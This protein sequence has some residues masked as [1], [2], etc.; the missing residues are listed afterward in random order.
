M[1]SDRILLDPTSEVTP[2]VRQ[3]VSRPAFR[4]GLN[5]GLLDISKA[6]GNIFLD[7]LAEIMKNKGLQVQRY[8]KPTFARV[9]PTNL[10]QRLVESCDA[11]IEA[12]AD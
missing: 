4:T 9:A 3:R 2:A 8:T 6:R 7:R 12:L 5:V 1:K 10:Q 11:V